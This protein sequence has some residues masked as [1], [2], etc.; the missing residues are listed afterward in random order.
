MTESIG[1]GYIICHPHDKST[2]QT[3]FEEIFF[4]WPPFMCEKINFKQSLLVEIIHDKIFSPGSLCLCG[5]REI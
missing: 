2:I 1:K 5:N 3:L 4:E